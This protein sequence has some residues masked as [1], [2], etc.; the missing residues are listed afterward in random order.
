VQVLLL[1]AQNDLQ[2]EE[3]PMNKTLEP[4]GVI[5]GHRLSHPVAQKIFLYLS[6]I[7]FSK[8]YKIIVL[9][10]SEDNRSFN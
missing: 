2:C 4:A 9:M 10:R 6:L 8:G 5:G 3:G 1:L 7:I